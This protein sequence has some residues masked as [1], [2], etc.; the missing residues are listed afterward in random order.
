MKY[1][2][3]EKLKFDDDPKL[4]IGETE[5]TVRSDAEAVL[6]LVDV[7]SSRGEAAGAREAAGLLFSEKDQKKLSRL[8]LK[9][10]DYLSVM[11]AAVQLAMGGDPGEEDNPAAG[12]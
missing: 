3:T 5:L 10:D 4:V 8:R 6:A 7:L 1:D 11:K 9:M 2:L 12:E